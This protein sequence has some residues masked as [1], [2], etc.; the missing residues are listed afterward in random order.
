MSGLFEESKKRREAKAKEHNS[1]S[2]SY[3]DYLPHG[4]KS[5]ATFIHREALR[6]CACAERGDM[7]GV[8][9]HL[10]DMATFGDLT[11]D[12]FFGPSPQVCPYLIS[13]V[14]EKART[15]CCAS[16]RSVGEFWINSLC[17]SNAFRRCSTYRNMVFSEM[18][19]SQT[20]EKSR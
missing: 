8:K 5:A 14:P 17:K 9:E 4:I 11:Y 19:Y 7:D 20:E 2:V 12:E 18:A 16:R 10:I 13:N 6:V 15:L 1:S 3:R